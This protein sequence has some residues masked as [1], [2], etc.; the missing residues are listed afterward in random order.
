MSLY[1]TLRYIFQIQNIPVNKIGTMA[2][3]TNI[4]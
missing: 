3:N 4:L 1:Y 2:Y